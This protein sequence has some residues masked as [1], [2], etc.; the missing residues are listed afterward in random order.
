MP[1]RNA[2]AE[3]NGTL[4]EGRGVMKLGSVAFEADFSHATR[5][6]EQPGTNPEEFVGAA[7]SGCFSMFLASQLTNAGYPPKQIRTR[8]KV[9]LGDGPRIHLIE[10][11]TE[12]EVP[13]ISDQLFQE[14]VAVSK[15]KCPVSMALAGPEIH[16]NAQLV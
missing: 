13:N 2:S 15:S 5:F 9:H 12:A 1:V 14:K 3:W 6:Q 8:A 4:K 11:D 7:L 10:L 16:V